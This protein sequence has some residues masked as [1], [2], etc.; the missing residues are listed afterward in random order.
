MGEDGQGMKSGWDLKGLQQQPPI[1]L[2]CGK[3]LKQRQEALSE[4]SFLQGEAQGSVVAH[5]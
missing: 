2:L 1:T 4:T 5:T 3:D